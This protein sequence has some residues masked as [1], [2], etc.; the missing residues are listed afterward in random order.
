MIPNLS[1]INSYLDSF[2]D[3]IN[4]NRLDAG[5]PSNNPF[6]NPAK[7]IL[8]EEEEA[9]HRSTVQMMDDQEMQEIERENQQIR[10]INS[11]FDSVRIVLNNVQDF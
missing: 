5:H 7:P 3:K 9:S 8:E 10:K 4:K 11:V 6:M 1:K 2:V